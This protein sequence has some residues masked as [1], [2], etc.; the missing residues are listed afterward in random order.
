MSFVA[1][2]SGNG[3]QLYILLHSFPPLLSPVLF[4]CIPVAAPFMLAR[5]YVMAPNM[6][7]ASFQGR[8]KYIQSPMHIDQP[9]RMN[10]IL[11][12]FSSPVVILS[13]AF[14]AL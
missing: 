1:H 8:A 6:C 12:S 5:C 9:L 11:C 14:R 13:V 7:H 4:Y 10:R 2:D 3:I